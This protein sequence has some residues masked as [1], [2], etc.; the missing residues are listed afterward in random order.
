[1]KRDNTI[2]LLKLGGSL[3]TDKNKPLSLREDVINSTI[4]QIIES[5]KKIVLIHGGGSFG[6]PIAKNYQ[7]S[8]GLNTSIKNQV[9]G[10][11]KTHEAMNQLNTIIINKFLKKNYPVLS[12][13]PSTI[14][15]KRS[16]QFVLNST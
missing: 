9:L 3:L 11:S 1:M 14:F 12:I 7:L 8:E 2:Y 10:L 4:E 16:Q 6:H 13:S 15:I 5:N